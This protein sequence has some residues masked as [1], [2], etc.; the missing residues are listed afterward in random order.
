[1]DMRMRLPKFG[2]KTY[3]T[4]GLLAAVVALVP[5][6]VR[7]YELSGSSDAPTLLLGDRV[8]VSLAAY[9]VRFP[10]TEAVLCTR[11]IPRQG[12]LVLVQWPG[13]PGPVFKRVVATGGDRVAMAAHHLVI[14][15]QPLAYAP[16][17]GSA[18]A[19]APA[20]NRLGSAFEVE[21]VGGVEHLISF[22]PG[23]RDSLAE[24]IVPEGECYLLGDNRD[25]SLDSRDKGPVPYGRVGGKV[26]SA[27]D[28]R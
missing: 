2:R 13:D 15:G 25:P 20:E 3:W 12:D 9:Q 5:S 27:P 26:V 1:M 23:T 4:T 6:Y 14:N 18:F 10:Y 17:D 11:A 28:R 19:A 7:A 8:L 24:V 22:T 16:R 21:T